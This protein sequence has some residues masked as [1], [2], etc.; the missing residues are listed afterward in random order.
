MCYTSST[1]WERVCVHPPG[2]TALT[3]WRR[4]Q[5][6]IEKRDRQTCGRTDG[7]TDGRTLDRYIDTAPP[8]T[9]SGDN[10]KHI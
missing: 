4:R 9:S 8:E 3:L 10:Y 7:R 2:I 6:W 1:Q 5:I